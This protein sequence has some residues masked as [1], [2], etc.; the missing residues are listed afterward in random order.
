MT[1]FTT[2]DGRKDTQSVESAQSFYTQSL[3][4]H[5]LPSIREWLIKDIKQMHT[6]I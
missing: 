2:L 4:H 5:V 6:D 1:D 3:S